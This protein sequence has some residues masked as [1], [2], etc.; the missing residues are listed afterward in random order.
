MK[1]LRLSKMGFLDIQEITMPKTHKFLIYVEGDSEIVFFNQY[2]NKYAKDN[3][4]IN[5]ECQQGDIPTFKRYIKR[6]MYNDYKE[7]FVLRD[8]KTQKDGYIDY[9]CITNMKSDFV[10][11]NTNK[12]IGNIGRSYKFIIVCNEIESWLLTHKKQTNNRSEKHIKE[13]FM[14]F[15]CTKKPECIKKIVAKIKRN[16]IKINI[17]NNKSLQYFIKKLKEC[18]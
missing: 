4:D 14:D 2:F 1:L 15:E 10:T 7:I 6:G 18:K 8:L 16:E 3:L 5:L 9:S 17:D 13:L 12:F 11:K